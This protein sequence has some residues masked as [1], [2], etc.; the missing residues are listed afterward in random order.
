[1]AAVAYVE[2]QA[3]EL[4]PEASK[5]RLCLHLLLERGILESPQTAVWFGTGK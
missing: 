5:I 2:I 4:N 1:M 3:P